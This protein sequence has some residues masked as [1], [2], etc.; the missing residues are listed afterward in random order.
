MDVVVCCHLD[1]TG[2]SALVRDGSD[3][4]CSPRLV[5]G[6]GSVCFNA[7]PHGIWWGAQCEALDALH[8]QNCSLCAGAPGS[9]VG[10]CYQK[11]QLQL[12][13]QV[14]AAQNNLLVEVPELP[15]V[16]WDYLDDKFHM[17]ANLKIIEADTYTVELFL[18]AVYWV[19][20][21]LHSYKYLLG[22]Y[23]CLCHSQNTSVRLCDR[24]SEKVF[25]QRWLIWKEKLNTKISITV[26]VI[27]K[28]SKSHR[29]C[30]V[31]LT[32]LA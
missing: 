29:G 16:F 6:C 10:N 8:Q 9:M 27:K 23:G 17:M 11:K 5:Q 2:V 31:K 21:G 18:G 12:C 22:E 30:W 15:G 1:A 32:V 28:Q 14:A 19:Y 24:E 4:A 20:C 25:Q 13:V 7:E 26:E 3:A